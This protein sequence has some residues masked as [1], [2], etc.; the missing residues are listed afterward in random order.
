MHFELKL[1]MAYAR[2]NMRLEKNFGYFLVDRVIAN[3]TG[4]ETS[5][6]THVLQVQFIG[7]F[8]TPFCQMKANPSI[9]NATKGR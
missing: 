2:D 5:I 9:A 8:C 7:C 3:V 6:V 1:T 4:M